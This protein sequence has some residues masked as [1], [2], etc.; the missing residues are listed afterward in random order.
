[1]NGPTLNSIHQWS[2]TTLCLWF[3]INLLLYKHP[4]SLEVS[5]STSIMQSSSS[6][7][8]FLVKF[9]FELQN[10]LHHSCTSNRGNFHQD[11]LCTC[12]GARW[13]KQLWVHLNN[14]LELS[15]RVVLNRIVY[16]FHL[17]LGCDLDRRLK[18]IVY[19]SDRYISI[20]ITNTHI[21]I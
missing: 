5:S 16:L 19:F 13:V 15:N 10:C 4:Q 2:N 8:V 14:L 21:F 11:R 7:V 9:R 17:V 12:Q 20:A 3:K 1:M 6:L 18:S